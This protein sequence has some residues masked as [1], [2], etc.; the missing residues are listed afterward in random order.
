LSE[1][2]LWRKKVTEAMT[3]SVLVIKTFL[4]TVS[5]QSCDGTGDKMIDFIQFSGFWSDYAS[6]P[7]RN[8]LLDG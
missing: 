2:E 1:K 3:L 6:T 5:I 7:G 8:Q 4:G